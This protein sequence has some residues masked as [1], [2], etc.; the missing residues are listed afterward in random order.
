MQKNNTL[1]HLPNGIKLRK[2]H[3]T[4][5]VV[6]DFFENKYC[7]KM[8]LSLLTMEGASLSNEPLRQFGYGLNT[9]TSSA[10]VYLLKHLRRFFV[11]LQ[12]QLIVMIIIKDIN[13]WLLMVQ[14]FK[15]QLI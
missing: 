8:I 10:F 11:I 13:S 2:S 1:Q 12:Q 7:E 15:S 14:I 6:W 4:E 3:I 5:N 9:A